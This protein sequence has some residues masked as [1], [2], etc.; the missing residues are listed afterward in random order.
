[1]EQFH[2]L[3]V[4]TDV[5]NAGLPPDYPNDVVFR[6]T[7]TGSELSR[8][9]IPA[10]RRVIPTPAAPTAG[11][12]TPEPPHRINQI[13]L[14]PILFAHAEARRGVTIRNRAEATA[15]EQDEQGVTVLARDLDGGAPIEVRARFLIGC[16]G[17]RSTVR[18]AIGATFVGTP[19]IQKVQSTYLRAP[20]LLARI[21]ASA[22]GAAT[23]ST[24][25][26]AASASRSTAARRSW[27]TTT[28]SR[29]KPT[30]TRSIATRRSGTS[31]ASAPTSATT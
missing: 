31:S 22:H 24:R 8:I 2:R 14:E 3:G 1:M 10:G 19:V 21:R 4:G 27:S 17:G 29:A 5:R 26:A 13:Y 11:G 6:T 20:D 30:S 23:R 28:S 7:V 16:D 18:K 15:F 12:P 25:A 9:H